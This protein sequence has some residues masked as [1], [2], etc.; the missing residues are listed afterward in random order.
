MTRYIQLLQAHEPQPTAPPSPGIATNSSSKPGNR[1]LQLLHHTESLPTAPHNGEATAPPEAP[2]RAAG[3]LSPRRGQG[4]KQSIA[5]E[6][7]INQSLLRLLSLSSLP[8]ESCYMLR[9]CVAS[10][11]CLGVLACLAWPASCCD[12]SDNHSS[13]KGGEVGGGRCAEWR[14][15]QLRRRLPMVWLGVAG[16]ARWRGLLAG[17]REGL[18][19]FLAGRC[20]SVHRLDGENLPGGGRVRAC[21]L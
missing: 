19:F 9:S 1:Y 8:K 15:A 5:T 3:V 6:R 2:L 10:L 13:I 14:R 4:G 12:D 7:Q 16:A 21:F 20:F 17:T 18:V 11:A